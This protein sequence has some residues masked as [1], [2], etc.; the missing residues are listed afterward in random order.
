MLNAGA[1]KLFG[2]S[3]ISNLILVTTL[4]A[5]VVLLSNLGPQRTS[6][7]LATAWFKPIWLMLGVIGTPLVLF[8]WL[9]MLWHFSFVYKA[10]G[11]FKVAWLASLILG[12]WVL[13]P[14]YYFLVYQWPGGPGSEGAYG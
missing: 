2:V 1:Q 8:L 12:N 5:L 11:W 3:V 14:L 9:G 10:N 6:L 7:I 13:A 4:A